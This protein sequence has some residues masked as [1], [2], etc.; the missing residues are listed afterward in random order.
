M[1]HVVGVDWDDLRHFQGTIELGANATGVIGTRIHK[2]DD[3]LIL[4]EYMPAEYVDEVIASVE[5]LRDRVKQRRPGGD[6]VGQ[7]PLPL[8]YAWRKQWEAGPKQHGLL[9]RAFFRSKFMDSE[10]AKFRAGNI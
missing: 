3:E 2:T 5:K 4:E 10:N 6:L 7:I 1:Q 8:W 9:W